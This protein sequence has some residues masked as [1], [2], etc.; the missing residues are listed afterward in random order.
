MSNSIPL[1]HEI[2]VLHPELTEQSYEEIATGA[3]GE[4]VVTV[5]HGSAFESHSEIVVVPRRLVSQSHLEYNSRKGS[6][7]PNGLCRMECKLLEPDA[8]LPYR[9]RETD[10][11]YDI[12]SYEN[13]ELPPVNR[14]NPDHHRKTL[15]MVSTGIAL[16][17]PPGFY[18]TIEGRS[19]LGMAEVVP[20]RGIIDA[21]YTG[22]LK[23]GLTNYSDRPYHVKKFERIAQVIVHRQI[24][25]EIVVVDKFSP[26]Y[27]QRGQAGF[28]S[29][30]K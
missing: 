28:G 8:K 17:A 5:R 15:V 19:G 7:H 21:T 4:T 20:F 25:M 1:V 10:A 6:H 2:Y 18:F 23:I 3:P 27:D 24:D 22:E 13:V 16:S 12:F 26:E 14:D 29:S 30:G 9:K 11:A